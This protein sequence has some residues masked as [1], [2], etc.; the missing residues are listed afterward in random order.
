M[1]TLRDRL[2]LSMDDSEN[3]SVQCFACLVHISLWRDHDPVTRKPLDYIHTHYSK[4][5][6][7][8]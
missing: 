7:M 6:W 1:W 5:P 2:F 4:C 3:H 8:N